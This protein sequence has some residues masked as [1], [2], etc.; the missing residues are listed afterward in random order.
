[1][2]IPFNEFE[3]YIDETILKRGLSYFRNGHVHEPQEIRPGE[4]EAIVEGTEDYI[5][6]IT[7]KNGMVTRY[8]CTCPY[9]MGPV[10]KHVVA[11]IFYLQQDELDL[12]K[13]KGSKKSS[14]T[15][16]KAKRKTVTEQV[17][18]LLGKTTRDE[19]E[20][21][22]RENAIQNRSF[23]YLF[24][25]SFVQYNTDDSKEF[26]AKQLSSILESAYDRNGFIDWSELEHVGTA[27]GNLLDYGQRQMEKH[28]YKSAFYV[29]TA[30]MEKLTGTL[31]YIDN[32]N[33][34]IN[35]CITTAFEM[36][37]Q[38]ADGQK[39]EEIRKM[40]LDYCLSAF[41]KKIYE[42]WDWHIE[43]LQIA[44]LLIKSREEKEQIVSLFDKADLSDYEREEAQ[45]IIY[46]LILKTESG[47]E[48]AKYLE[49]NL[50]NPNMRR[51]AIR[52]AFADKDYDRADE[53]ARD[54][55]KFDIKDKPGL[56]ME[57]YDWLLKIAQAKRDEAKI[58]EYARY[59]LI[60]NFRHEQDYYKILKEHV[61]PEKWKSFLESVI[62]DISA[63]RPRH[64]SG[65]IARI[66]I[67]EEWWDRLLELVKKSPYLTT[68]ESYEKYLAEHYPDEIAAL[69]S[70]G[71]LKYIKNNLGRKHYREACRYLRRMI[72][73][74]ARDKADEIIEFLKKEYPSRRALLEE[75]DY[76]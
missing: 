4:Y 73:L 3:Q 72:K 19:L 54:G 30:V 61:K 62:Q 38:M 28:N 63:N 35:M 17:D 59:L 71:I 47:K 55:V 22:I 74:G 6:Y 44:S 57:W 5:V 52:K 64:D 11:V 75:L 9:D 24:L 37:Y 49:E 76:V 34:D 41:D 42:G 68:I 32:S 58:I 26:Y 31:E 45:C 29:C 2:Q 53:I 67:R 1:M 15:I 16:K 51:E 10:C 39:D 66:F 65:L 20:Q 69:Y 25:S 27:V 8:I 33:E 56:A 43:M 70:E 46:D 14:L 7:L 36:L 48:A 13:K 12:K 60:D 18:E 50:N 40:I 23:R 21:F